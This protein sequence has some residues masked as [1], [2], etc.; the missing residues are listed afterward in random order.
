MPRPLVKP[1]DCK[2]CTGAKQF[3]RYHQADI[4]MELREKAYRLHREGFT[5]AQIARKLGISEQSA[6]RYVRW[7]RD[8]TGG[9]LPEDVNLDDEDVVW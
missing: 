6:K 8:R 3:C 5:R 9:L 7:Y 2:M 4:V 1:Q